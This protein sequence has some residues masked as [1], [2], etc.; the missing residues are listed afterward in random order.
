MN[1]ILLCQVTTIEIYF[2]FNFEPENKES[3]I[4]ELFAAV[5]YFFESNQRKLS[6]KLHGT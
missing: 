3:L 5:N 4:E 6:E 1:D 2:H